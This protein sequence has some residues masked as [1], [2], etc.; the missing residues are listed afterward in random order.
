M[1]LDFSNSI[2]GDSDALF[3]VAERTSNFI[4]IIYY[5]ETWLL[6]IVVVRSGCTEDIHRRRGG[7]ERA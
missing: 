1:H 2:R 3:F 5:L 6:L 7:E 4:Q